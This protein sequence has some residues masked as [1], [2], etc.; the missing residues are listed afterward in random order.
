MFTHFPHDIF[1]KYVNEADYN[2]VLKIT[3]HTWMKLKIKLLCSLVH[4]Q[5]FVNLIYE[6]TKNPDDFF[7]VTISMTQHPKTYDYQVDYD[8][9][10]YTLFLKPY[11][12]IVCL[13]SPYYNRHNQLS[14]PL[15]AISF[16]NHYSTVLRLCL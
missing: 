1:E 15:K 7:Q 14:Y 12:F 3:H 6:D 13:D 5:W 16:K 2:A 9:P 4:Y 8:K 11:S 10:I